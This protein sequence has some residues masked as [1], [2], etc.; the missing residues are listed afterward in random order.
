MGSPESE[1]QRETDEVQHN[2]T[3]SNFY[4]GRY[5]VTQKQY[6]KV[7]GEN[8]S[9]F[10]GDNLP[11]ENVSW[12][13]A[14]EFCNKLSQNEGLTPVY[15][16]DGDNDGW[17]RS[18]NGYRLPTEAEWE[19]AARAGTTTPFN[20]E[21]SISD[22]E[23]NYYGHYPYGI[24][25]N[26]FSQEN[27]ETEPGEYR[28]TTVEV[29]SFSPN[30]WGLYNTHGNVAEWCFDYYGAYDL[31]NTT[32]PSG[33]TTGTL[34]INRGGGWNDYAKHLRC[35]YRASTTP[36]QKMNN[37]G[38]RLARNGESGT[39]T[40]NENQSNNQEVAQAQNNATNTNAEENQN[41][42]GTGKALV[43]YF[44]HTGNTENVANFIH[45]AVGGDI[46]KLETEE[47]YTDNYNDLLDIAQE[48]KRENARPALSTKIDNIEQYDTIFLGYP[49]WWGDM[50][51]ALYTFLDEYDLSGKTIAPFVTSGGSGLSGTPSN[52][53]EEEPNATVTEGLSVRDT[54]SENSQNQVNEWLSEI[55]F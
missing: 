50:P 3:V 6:E 18:A 31:E 36:D 16:I 4:I 32:N 27:L 24:E 51:M 9:N 11:V 33:P 30:K 41:T 8:P 43:V 28:Q 1:M 13:D 39:Q 21:D 34:R 40:S 5:E 38:F 12:Y 42:E 10:K 2:V 37:I 53:Q 19:Y 22:E 20:T 25:E 29:D 44:S 49:I 26:Y 47:P 48:E 55:G 54:N 35:A 17:D 23:A 45:E 14:I 46:V 15:T 7:M 52:I